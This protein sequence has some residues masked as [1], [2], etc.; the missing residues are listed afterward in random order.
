MGFGLVLILTGLDVNNYPLIIWEIDSANRASQLG[1]VWQEGE[2]SILRAVVLEW[3]PEEFGI[4]WPA[5]ASQ[6]PSRSGMTDRSYLWNWAVAA[7]SRRLIAGGVDVDLLVTA[8]PISSQPSTELL[9]NGEVYGARVIPMGLTITATIPEDPDLAF[10]ILEADVPPVRQVRDG[11][12]AW[13]G[14]VLAQGAVDL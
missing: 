2:P 8:P 14:Q 12:Q 13:W 5:I 4:G 10:L 11:T 9:I 3:E 1:T 7:A 6:V